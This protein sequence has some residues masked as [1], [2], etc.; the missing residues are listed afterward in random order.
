MLEALLILLAV[1]LVPRFDES[2]LWAALA[3]LLVIPGMYATWTGAPFVPTSKRVMNKMIDLAHIKPGDVVY[4]LGCGDGRF[5]FA[6]KKLGA[7]ATGFEYSI[8]TYL[9]AKLRALF[10]PGARI[11]FAN[12]WLVNISDADVVFCYLLT[13]S[14]QVFARKIWPQLKPGCRVVSH[15]FRMK[16]IQPAKDEGGVVLYVK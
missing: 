7:K 5:V 4:D 15:S 3:A 16:G 6:A 2:P 11:R 10:H 1:F 14:M 13:D 9:L 8:P 12:F